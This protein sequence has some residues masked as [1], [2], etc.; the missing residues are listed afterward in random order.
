MAGKLEAGHMWVSDNV[1]QELGYVYFDMFRES[2]KTVP[3]GV[4]I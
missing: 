2:T 4:V 1:I 3:E